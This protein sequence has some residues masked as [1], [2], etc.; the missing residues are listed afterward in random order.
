MRM[1]FLRSYYYPRL[2]SAPISYA[3]VVVSAANSYPPVFI[4]KLGYTRLRAGFP[5]AAAHF[6]AADMSR[7]L[8]R[9]SA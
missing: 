1:D 9:M 5:L 6:T 4:F 7:G 2:I 3:R 8:S